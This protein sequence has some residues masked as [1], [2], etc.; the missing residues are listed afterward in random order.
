MN[1]KSTGAA[2]FDYR[3]WRGGRETYLNTYRRY[4]F[5]VTVRKVS[6]GAPAPEAR[7]H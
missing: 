6:D 3:A 1:G 4:E 5:P 7:N 2:T